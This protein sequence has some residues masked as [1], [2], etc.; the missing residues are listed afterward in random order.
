MEPSTRASTSRSSTQTT[1]TPPTPSTARP[2]LESEA[3]LVALPKNTNGTVDEGIDIALLK[4]SDN[5]TANPVD[6]TPPPESDVYSAAL[7]ENTD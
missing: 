1:T 3:H 7:P 2:P 5:N 4:P 6:G